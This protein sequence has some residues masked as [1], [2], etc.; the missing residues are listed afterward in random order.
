MTENAGIIS[1]SANYNG[2]LTDEG[3]YIV[4]IICIISVT[5]ELCTCSPQD[6]CQMDLELHHHVL[7]R[8]LLS[9]LLSE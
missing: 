1:Y 5:T 3:I 8:Q 9:L 4:C 7:H 2:H 6:P